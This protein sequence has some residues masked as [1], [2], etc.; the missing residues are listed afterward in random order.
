ME[1]R[2]NDVGVNASLKNIEAVY[3]KNY[4]RVVSSNLRGMQ[5]KP[6]TMHMLQLGKIVYMELQQ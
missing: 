1:E 2:R 3:H 5:T 4:Q 6:D